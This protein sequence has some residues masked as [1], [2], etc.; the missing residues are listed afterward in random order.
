VIKPVTM[1]SGFISGEV[2]VLG[3][4]S[5]IVG[6]NGQAFTH[7]TYIG[8]LYVTYDKQID[9]VNVVCLIPADHK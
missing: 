5:R 9:N 4:I 8:L 3:K 6:G 2:G 1:Q 7:V